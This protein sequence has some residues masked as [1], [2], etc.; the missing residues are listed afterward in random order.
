MNLNCPHLKEVTITEDIRDPASHRWK[1]FPARVRHVL[2]KHSAIFFF[3]ADKQFSV[4]T[5]QTGSR[6]H[7]FNSLG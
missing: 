7:S 2:E 6:A 1:V 5:L 3:L 4:F